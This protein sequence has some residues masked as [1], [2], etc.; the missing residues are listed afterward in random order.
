MIKFSFFKNPKFQ[1]AE[2][3]L[4]LFSIAYTVISYH[5]PFNQAAELV[6]YEKQN[7]DV[8]QIN[9]S[10]NELAITFKGSDLRK[11][12]KG[13]K[14]YSIKLK[15]DGKSGIDISKRL[16]GLQFQNAQ[17]INAEIINAKDKSLVKT[18]LFQIQDSNKV[19]LTN[20]ILKEKEYIYF[21]ITVI[22]NNKIT[23][24]VTTIGKLADADLEYDTEGEE[25]GFWDNVWIFIKLIFVL[26][27]I[28]FGAYFFVNGLE[29]VY[30]YI[31]TIVKRKEF[32]RRMSYHYSEQKEIHR[33][34]K[35]LYIENSKTDFTKF[36]YLV[37]DNIGL[38]FF[39]SNSI[40]SID[41][42]EGFRKL[43]DK[44]LIKSSQTIKEIAFKDDLYNMISESIDEDYLLKEENSNFYSPSEEFRN[45]L[46]M[47][48]WC[49]DKIPQK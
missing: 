42:V 20:F 12:H 16:V 3:V 19:Y 4:A 44:D 7:V 41:T 39:I 17:I 2:R 23:P 13:L 25:N 34:L 28:F 35:Q 37:T 22:H 10:L 5:F 48:K 30:N 43:L 14:V 49:F 21:K 24:I 33:F 29:W 15:N 31:K 36:I 45:E 32:M 26:L 9:D 47:I 38:N 8:Y 27:G 40:K 18:T 1:I 6:F 46:E 11:E